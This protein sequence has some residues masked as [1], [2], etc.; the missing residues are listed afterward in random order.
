MD[1][2]A[3]LVPPCQGA[4][5]AHIDIR[6]YVYSLASK[7]PAGALR[8]V[9]ESNPFA[10]VCG[11]V[12]FHP[13]EDACRRERVDSAIS[14]MRLKRF[15]A[16]HGK[17]SAQKRDV[18]P[19]N[20]KKI[21]IIGAGPAGLTAAYDLALL[22]YKSVVFE[23]SS[24]AGGMLYWGIPEYRLPKSA[25]RKDIEHIKSIGVEILT[26][27]EIGTKVS[28]DDLKAEGFDAYILASGLPTS[29]SLDI[30]GADNEYVLTAIPFLSSIAAGKPAKIGDQ[31]IVIGGGNVAIDVARSA[32]RLGAKKVRLACLEARDEMPAHEWEILEA[33]EE[34]IEIHCSKGPKE[35][36]VKD[37][38]VVGL[39]MMEVKCVFDK[40][41]RFNPKFHHNKLMTLS[42]DT[43]IIAVGQQSELAFV[44]DTG[45]D[46]NERGQVIVN[47][48]TQQSSRP[49]VFVCGEVMTGPGAAIDA[50]AAGKRAAIK[51][52]A[53]L[54][55][56]DPALIMDDAYEALDELSE[57]T[58]FRISSC[59]RMKPEVITGKERVKDFA[60][61][62]LGY[63]TEDVIKEAGRCLHCLGG[64]EVIED[65]CV[66]CLTCERICPFQAPYVDR[67]IAGIDDVACQAC[68]LCASECPAEAIDM[69][70]FNDRRVLGE[71]L[72]ATR[73]KPGKVALVCQYGSMDCVGGTDGVPAG[74]RIFEVM[75]PGKLDANF[76][77]KLFE[78][79]AKSIAFAGCRDDM[80]R[81]YHGKE[82]TLARLTRV[83]ELVSQAGYKDDA[84]ILPEKPASKRKERS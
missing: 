31:V 74:Y 44:K 11:R 33:L 68:G 72:K 1:P 47:K 80:C 9:L 22:G 65:K 66:A 8:I 46:L 29:R 6:G 63:T 27:Q 73:G 83:K 70:L 12:C 53:F 13:C 38:K 78:N 21:A 45:I 43:V 79:G 51:A 54:N 17:L 60:E 55:G 19:D 84:V 50:I 23:K 58:I 35:I 7:D 25:L 77:L 32:K 5:P 75:C 42:G 26:N 40:T 10:S 24:V 28:W 57:E 14:I 69:R 64:A 2:I 34:D 52:D 4:C 48:V 61:M 49:D 39:E 62:E 36:I 76:Y 41:G 71:I 67:G 3:K 82:K 56:I 20:G 18:S 30:P 16:D 37:G 15:A 59:A 81:F